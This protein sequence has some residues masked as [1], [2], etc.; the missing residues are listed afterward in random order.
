MSKG[1]IYATGGRSRPAYVAQTLAFVS[2][3]RLPARAADPADHSKPPILAQISAPMGNG[4][5]TT[6]KHR[7]SFRSGDKGIWVTKCDSLNRRQK[8]IQK[9]RSG[10]SGGLLNAFLNNEM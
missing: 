3:L 8:G 2:N 5:G 10:R 1:R 7:G 9:R 4:V 6:T